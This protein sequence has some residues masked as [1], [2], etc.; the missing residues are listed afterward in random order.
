M[1]KQL[2][3]AVYRKSAHT[4]VVKTGC[5]GKLLQGEMCRDKTTQPIMKEVSV[6]TMV[7]DMPVSCVCI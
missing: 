5:N 2:H 6:V 4:T 3:M 1:V 7:F